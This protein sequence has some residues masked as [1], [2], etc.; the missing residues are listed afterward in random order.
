MTTGWLIFNIV[1]VIV[2]A[3]IVALPA[4]L[5]PHKLHRHAQNAERTARSAGQGAN[6]RSWAVDSHT[7]TPLR[8][9]LQAVDADPTGIAGRGLVAFGETV[10]SREA[11]IA[12]RRGQR[13]DDS[14]TVQGF[15]RAQHLKN[16]RAFAMIRACW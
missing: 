4:V 2:V 7:A 8:P 9:Q 16:E 14:L 13:T 3:A 6:S 11:R 5:I 15:R 1:L 10:I 12:L